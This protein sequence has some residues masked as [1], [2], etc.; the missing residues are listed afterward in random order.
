M[1]TPTRSFIP[2]CALK[3]S[4]R[5][6]CVVVAQVSQVCTSTAGADLSSTSCRGTISFSVPRAAQRCIANGR[7]EGTPRD[8]IAGDVSLGIVGGFGGL[9]NVRP[10]R[11][12]GRCDG[13][14]VATGMQLGWNGSRISSASLLCSDERAGVTWNE[15]PVGGYDYSGANAP[16]HAL[17][18][19]S[20]WAMTG[21]VGR[22]SDVELR[23]VQVACTPI[24]AI[25]EP[26]RSRSS[27][28]AGPSIV[29]ERP[30]TKK[31]AR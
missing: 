7:P 4:V 25:P 16:L 5:T 29:S 3:A 21:F 24:S 20:G 31:L 10:V 19:P 23:Q 17:R 12:E 18:C 28:S 14:E 15:H 11:S 2:Y 30:I 6:Q 1:F 8:A 22:Q 9:G 27:V 13:D 26:D